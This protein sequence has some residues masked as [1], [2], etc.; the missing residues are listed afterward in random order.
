MDIDHQKVV[1]EEGDPRI[2][3]RFA[4][5]GGGAHIFHDGSSNDRVINF[6]LKMSGGLIK[7]KKIA[8]IIGLFLTVA[9]F[10][11]SIIWFIKAFSGPKVS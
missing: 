11:I 2:A 5:M 6:I 9:M 10:V 8:T 7:S 3:R 1:F 4:Q